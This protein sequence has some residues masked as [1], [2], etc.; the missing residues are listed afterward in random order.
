[1]AGYIV[2]TIWMAAPKLS[3]GILPSKQEA[4]AF[5]QMWP[6][7]VSIFQYAMTKI[8][9][10]GAGSVY[11]KTGPIQVRS[12]LQ[13]LY[14]FAFLCASLPHIA[15]WTISL[16]A[17]AFPTVFSP[18]ILPL[19][20][21]NAVFQNKFPWS[22]EQPESLG[23]GALWFL[24]WDHLCCTVTA[25]VWAVTL[26]ESAHLTNGQSVDKSTLA[27][28]VI[29]F[30]LIAGV[31]GAAVELMWE[32]DQFLLDLEVTEVNKAVKRE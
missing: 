3:N 29:T 5:W 20:M 4:I 2:P 21:P 22:P 23:V 6:V 15:C 7:W 1:M 16:S 9:G 25:L 28:K 26:Y 18:D 11:P 17:V 30:T 32:R 24:Q 12:G 8:M 19:L 27:L 31:A 14:G 10:A 13:F